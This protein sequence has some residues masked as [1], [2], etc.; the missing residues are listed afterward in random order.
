MPHSVI[1][2][3]RMK[4]RLWLSWV[5]FGWAAIV[6]ADSQLDLSRIRLPAGFNIAQGLNMPNGVAIHDGSLYVAEVSRYS[7]SIKLRAGSR[8]QRNLPW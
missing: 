5:V 7:V 4:T 8:L 2:G 1:S 6:S 3:N